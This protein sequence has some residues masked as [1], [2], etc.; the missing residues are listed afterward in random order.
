LDEQR[1]QCEEVAWVLQTGILVNISIRSGGMPVRG[2]G[3]QALHTASS[4]QVDVTHNDCF[5]SRFATIRL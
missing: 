2:S 3:G 1:F 5:A 4:T